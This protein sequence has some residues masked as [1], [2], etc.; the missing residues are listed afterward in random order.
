M[1]QCTIESGVT[2]RENVKGVRAHESVM[3]DSTMTLN[4]MRTLKAF[5]HASG[6][7]IRFYNDA[8]QYENARNVLDT[9]LR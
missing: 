7:S 2:Q 8:T 4:N 9:Y 5:R 6:F 3:H 1:I